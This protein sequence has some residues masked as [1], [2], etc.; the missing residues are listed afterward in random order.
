[1]YPVP[2]KKEEGEVKVVQWDL[3]ARELIRNTYRVNKGRNQLTMNLVKKRS[4]EN[5]GR[6]VEKTKTTKDEG[7]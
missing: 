5:F 7:I 4:E 6:E 3:S 2:V 1:M